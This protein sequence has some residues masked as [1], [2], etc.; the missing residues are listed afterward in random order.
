[1]LMLSFAHVRSP[2]STVYLSDDGP[3][4]RIV[5]CHISRSAEYVS[6][7]RTKECLPLTEAGAEAVRL[8]SDAIAYLKLRASSLRTRRGC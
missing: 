1:M 6:M 3:R 5:G 8:W 7:S 4:A 2:H